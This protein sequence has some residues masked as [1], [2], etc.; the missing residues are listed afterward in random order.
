[1]NYE[2]ESSGVVTP[3]D[4]METMEVGD[5]GVIIQSPILDYVGQYVLCAYRHT[6]D[7]KGDRQ[8]VSLTDPK[9]VWEH[10]PHGN[11]VRLL[12]PGEE[13]IIRGKN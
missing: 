3:V 7:F 11:K 6:S 12:Q 4:S 2:V 1:M 9:A 8:I 10:C 13:I 5:V